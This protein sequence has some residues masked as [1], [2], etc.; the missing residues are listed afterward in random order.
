[1]KK[2]MKMGLGVL[3]GVAVT[4][5]IWCAVCDKKT[6]ESDFKIAV[7]DIEKVRQGAEVYKTVVAEQKKYEDVWETKFKADRS[8]LDQEDKE[9]A[10]KRSK[11]KAKELRSSVELLQRKA[12]AL[13]QKYQAEAGKIIAATNSVVRQV[14]TVVLDVAQNMAKEQGYAIIL[15]KGV[16][17]YASSAVDL[18]DLFVE[19]LNKKA[20]KITYPDPDTL[21][22]NKQTPQK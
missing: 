22:P 15:P 8:A 3:A 20:I 21:T 10:A 13:Q 7:M 19:E 1:M 18:T 14:D 9:L 17:I 2:K 11:M 4:G 6:S 16:T 5:L 12:I